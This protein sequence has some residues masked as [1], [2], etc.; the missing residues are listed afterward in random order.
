MTPVDPAG[1]VRALKTR[2]VAEMAARGL[3]VVR[4]GYDP[5]D[6]GVAPDA[7]DLVITATSADVTT[8]VEQ[9]AADRSFDQ[10]VA[11]SRTFDATAGAAEALADLRRRMEG[12]GD[13]FDA[14]PE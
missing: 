8:P 12:G 5:S 9:L 4:F 7:L 14:E 2:V 11:D 10:I 1:D 13:L 6:D 3:T